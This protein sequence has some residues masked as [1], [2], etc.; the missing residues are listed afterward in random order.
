MMM[1]MRK[2]K[3]DARQVLGM[4][5]VAIILLTTSGISVFHHYCNTTRLSE[6]S[7]IIPEFS[8]QHHHHLTDKLP[9]CCSGEHENLH[10]SCGMSD[11]CTTDVVMVKLDVT[12]IAQD[13]DPW[14]TQLAGLIVGNSLMLEDEAEV[15]NSDL[16]IINNNHS[17]PLAGRDLH[18]YIHQLNIPDPSV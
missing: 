10:Q 4:F 6:Y 5:M 13:I 17:P 14:Q 11:C 12:L 18:I 15:E 2:H 9:S 8:C 1:N 3:F 7:L 16:P